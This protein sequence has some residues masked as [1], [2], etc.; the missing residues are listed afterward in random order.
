MI[1]QRFY[2]TTLATVGVA[3]MSATLLAADGIGFI[4][5]ERIFQGYYKTARDDAAFKTQKEAYEREAKRVAEEIE[6]I[7]AKRDEHRDASLNIALS[8]DVRKEHR[9]KVEESDGLYQEKKRELQTFLKKIDKELQGKYLELRQGIVDEISTYVRAYAER[10]GLK[11]VIDTSGMS[12]NM[13]PVVVY[14]ES[15]SDL[16]DTILAE[17]NRGHEDELPK[18]DEAKTD[19]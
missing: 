5:M 12:R 3:F 15:T 13:I 6:L 8:D 4:D 7:K 19:K 18:A 17:L 1:N 14:F 9:Q 2:R 11:A 16:T 10:E